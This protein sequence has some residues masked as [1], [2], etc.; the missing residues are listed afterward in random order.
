MQRTPVFVSAFLLLTAL[1]PIMHSATVAVQPDAAPLASVL[2]VAGTGFHP[3]EMVDI[4]LDTSDLALATSDLNGSFTADVT[5]PSS[6]PSGG[7]WITAAGRM[8]GMAAQ[9]DA[10]FPYSWRQFH[11]GPRRDG[12]NPAESVLS[13][14]NADKL[15]LA[16]SS[17]I[18]VFTSSPA[19]VNGILYVGSYDFK[20]H[21]L[22]ALTGASL[23]AAPTDFDIDSS[24]SIKD[25]KVYIGSDDGDFY[26]FDAQNGRR[27]WRVGAGEVATSAA[28]I[29][30]LAY[31]GSLDG[32]IYAFDAETGSLVWGEYTGGD[33]L[34]SSPAV[35]TGIA[36][37]GSVSGSV[38]AYNALNSNTVWRVNIGPSQPSSPALA[39]GIVCIAADKL[40]A[41]DALD[42]S[43]LWTADIGP[44][45]LS[46][47]S[48]AV[49]NGVVLIGRNKLYAFAAETGRPLWS[50]SVGNQ[51][52]SPLSIA[53][54]VAY[55]GTSDGHI[56]AFDAATGRLLWSFATEGY[57]FGTPA[58]ESGMVYASSEDG[59][60][61]AFGIPGVRG[62]DPNTPLPPNVA[63]L[64][65]DPAL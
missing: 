1:S 48:P 50:T 58:I 21:A 55:A 6:T 33:I 34:Y 7:H 28:L 46:Y 29:N 49:A 3:L 18:G 57:I 37:V 16:W 38:F 65:P 52:T 11:G 31:V 43:S 41:F 40:Y 54:G 59:N 22:D 42:G 64:I 45:E 39:Q 27:I 36:Y 4:Y 25:G 26:C 51:I 61:Y 24:P 56:Y 15:Q 44:A 12:Y 10:G 9:A 17:K 35:S 30:G 53:N 62:S 47:A 8:S 19:V 32:N 23:W 13:V 63:A 2:H 5:V 60:V 20:L 14:N